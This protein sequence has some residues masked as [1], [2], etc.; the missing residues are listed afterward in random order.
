MAACDESF[1]QFT[2]DAICMNLCTPPSEDSFYKTANSL[3]MLKK[4]CL[5]AENFLESSLK[6][7]RS[8]K[9]ASAHV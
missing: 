7:S 4:A 1:V 9:I 3:L 8:L 6:L 5:I 2:F